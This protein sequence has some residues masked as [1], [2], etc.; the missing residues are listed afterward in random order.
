MSRFRSS[1]ATKSPN[2]LAIPDSRTA[3]PLA[4]PRP[5]QREDPAPVDVQ[6][7]VVDRHEV[8][9]PLGNTGQSHGD[10]PPGIFLCPRWAF[11]SLPVFHA[12]PP[13]PVAP[14]RD[15]PLVPFSLIKGE[16]G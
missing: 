11:C 4:A 14:A 3:T 10:A 9:E 16:G 7:Q 2:R 5:P 13:V 12:Y 6:V 8:P 1:T 15:L